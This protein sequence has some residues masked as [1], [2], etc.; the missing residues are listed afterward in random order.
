MRTEGAPGRGKIPGRIKYC[1]QGS[2]H[3]KTLAEKDPLHTPSDI[4]NEIVPNY[5][6]L[7]L[8]IMA[9]IAELEP[10]ALFSRHASK[11]LQVSSMP[12]K[13]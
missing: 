4:K 11:R 1:G 9:R 2:D 12:E 5:F 7:V 10:G 13:R 8:S 3:S 6:A